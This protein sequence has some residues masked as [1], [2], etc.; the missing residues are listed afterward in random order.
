MSEYP[1]D[2]LDDE[3]SWE[4][5]QANQIGR[6]ASARE[7]APDI[8]PI[9]YVVHNWKIYFRTGAESRLRKETDG[10]LVAF[11]SGWQMMK[12]FS[13]TVALGVVRTLTSEEAAKVLDRLPIVDFAP[14]QDYVWMEL[15]PT[16]VRGRRLNVLDPQR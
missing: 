2:H 5:I 13:S 14:D 15:D 1:I 11:E 7:G 12:H 10:R 9:S 8:Y 6:I 4:I 16:E 3:E